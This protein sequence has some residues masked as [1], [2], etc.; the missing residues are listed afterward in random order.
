VSAALT[1]LAYSLKQEKLDFLNTNDD[2][3]NQ[4]VYADGKLWS[5]LNTAVAANGPTRPGI[6]WLVVT[7][8]VSGGAV[9][10]AVTRQGYIALPRDTV[11]FPSIGVNAAGKGV[12]AFSIG[13]PDFYP[14]TGYATI[15]FSSGVGP[16]RVAGAGAGPDDGFSGYATYGGSGRVARWGD[17]SAAVAAADGSIWSAAEYIP[18]GQRTLLAN[19]GTYVS[20]V[21][22]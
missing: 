8:S 7:P 14:S 12:V 11:M 16:V 15:D 17:Y 19:W 5:G 4:V 18:G 6:A 20:H 10:G 2:R 1:P 21:T 22:P 9:D 3:I 13:G